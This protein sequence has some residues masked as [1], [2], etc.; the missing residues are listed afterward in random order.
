MKI[1]VDVYGGDNAPK[2]IIKGAVA[3]LK[4]EQGFSLV[5]V[6]NKAE[7]N[8]LLQSCEYEKN[9]VEIIDA[10]DVITNEDIPTIALRKKTQSSLVKSFDKLNEDI[11]AKAF[12]S[13]GSTGATLTGA[14]LLLKRIQGIN[15]PGLAPLLPIM[16]SEKEVMLIDCGAVSD[17]KPLNLLQ[18]AQMGNAYMKAVVGE[19][20]PRI[21]LLSNGTEDGKGNER[22]KE[23]FRLLKEADIN[24][25]GNLEGRDILS[26][27]YDVVVADGFSGN[28]ALKASEGTALGMF[29]LIKDGIL[30]GG[31]RAKLGYIL[32]KPVF[33]KIKNKMD[34]NDKGGAVVLGLKKI[35]V[36]AHGSSKEKSICA[37]I[38][39]AKQMV[40]SNVVKKIEELFQIEQ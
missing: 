16:G 20:N 26:G 27:N 28:I 7:I 3:S 14:V 10:P 1:V 11:E 5:L 32:L 21:G 6:G 24:F 39:Q 15:R 38:L 2:E 33:K 23:A 34:Y 12:V 17:P 35:V 31:L 4:K 37:S 25:L 9:R 19:K 18:Y 29:S 8:Q 22:N 36:K 40:E 13:A 30:N